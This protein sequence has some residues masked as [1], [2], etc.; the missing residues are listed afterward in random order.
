MRPGSGERAPARGGATGGESG[1]DPAEA[2]RIVD[3]AIDAIVSGDPDGTVRSWNAG[4]E[5]LYGYSAEEDGR[6]TPL[7]ESRTT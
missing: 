2:A 1:I 7:D 5:R 3:S 4:A 6:S